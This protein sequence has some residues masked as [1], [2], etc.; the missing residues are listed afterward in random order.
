MATWEHFDGDD[1]VVQA[2]FKAY[3]TLQDHRRPRQVLYAQQAL[4]R[5]AAVASDARAFARA[6]QADGYATDPE[7]RRKLIKLMD[8]YDLYRFDN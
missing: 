8:R 3:F 4:L 1:V 2:P 7:L 5:C 6:I